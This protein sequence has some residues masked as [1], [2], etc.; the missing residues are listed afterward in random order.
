MMDPLK[1]GLVMALEMGWETWWALILGFTIAGAVESFVSEE[2]MTAVLGGSGPSEIGLG[3][4]FG[5]ASSSCSFG[6]VMS[7]IFADLIVPT[8]VDAYRRYYGGFM[9]G[10]LFAGIFLTA[11]VSGVIIHYIWT[12]LGLAPAPETLGGTAPGGYTTY[13]NSFFT[14]LFLLQLYVQFGTTPSE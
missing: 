13:L 6:G 5:A 2:K 4:L 7:F 10:V 11:V 1:E 12:G 9:A 8:I 3:T 14:V